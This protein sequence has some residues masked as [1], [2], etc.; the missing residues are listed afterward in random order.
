MEGNEVIDFAP[1][2]YRDK[3]LASA[4]KRWPCA[5]IRRVRWVWRTKKGRTKEYRTYAVF[6]GPAL[7]ATARLNR[8]GA[9]YWHQPYPTQ[10][11]ETV[12]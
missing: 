7:I 10:T 5:I 12:G 1:E 3:V 9:V 2:K 11:W 6:H 8:A 4:Q